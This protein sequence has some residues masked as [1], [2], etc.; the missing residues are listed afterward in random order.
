M[1]AFINVLSYAENKMA[2]KNKEIK[3]EVQLRTVLTDLLA[4]LSAGKLESKVAKQA[5]SLSNC[6]FAGV[7][8]KIKYEQLRKQKKI[9]RILFMEG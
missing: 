9:G 1:W 8:V 5:V 4:D 7:K 6:V 2:K 3:K